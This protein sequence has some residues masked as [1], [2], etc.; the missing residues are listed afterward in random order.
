MVDVD[1]VEIQ[2][3]SYHLKCCMIIPT[4]AFCPVQRDRAVINDAV[5]LVALPPESGCSAGPQLH[6]QQH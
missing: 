5:A 6:L 1:T 3:Y 2:Y 4:D